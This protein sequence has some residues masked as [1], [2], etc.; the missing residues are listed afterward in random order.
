MEHFLDI[1]PLKKA[2]AKTI[3]RETQW[4]SECL[5]KDTANAIYFTLPALKLPTT[6]KKVSMCAQHLLLR[7]NI[8]TTHLK[9]Q[10]V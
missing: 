7:G 3:F 6:L 10:N 1:V 8:S 4:S 5:E 9:E 2:D